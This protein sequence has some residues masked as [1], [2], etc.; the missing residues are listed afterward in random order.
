VVT[1]SA[2]GPGAELDL[3]DWG[4]VVLGHSIGQ[5]GMGIVYRGWLYYNPA[6]RFA[7]TPA[8]PVA[9]KVLHPLLQGRAQ[10]QRSFA[11]EAAALGRLSHP[12]IV[13]C[14][15]VTD[16]NGQLGLV[17]ELVQGE[18]LDQ[19][20]LRMQSESRALPCVPFAQAWH[21]FSQLLGALAAIHALGILHRDIKSAN[22]L[23]RADG[24]VKLTDFGIAQVSSE[25]WRNTGGATPG[26]GAYM[27]PEQVLGGTLD[28]RS[29]LYSAGIVLFEMLT[30][31]T[32]FDSPEKTE[33]MLRVAQLETTPPSITSLIPHAPLVLDVL[34]ARALAKEPGHRFGSAV[35]FG[36]SLR[37]SLGLPESAGW[38]AEQRLADVAQTLSSMGFPAQTPPKLEAEAEA[39]RSDLTAAF[40]KP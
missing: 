27:S 22:L 11:R 24:V 31:G 25:E 2:I 38:S 10:A 34:M 21:Y 23:I 12:N 35:E 26:T 32:P 15:G 33:V 39:L 30:G 1:P 19:L 4:K 36:E 18:P 7:G 6:G 40:R 20:I 9:V 29:D 13:H 17:M 5:G 3:A 37:N 16:F 8:H 14:F 28:P